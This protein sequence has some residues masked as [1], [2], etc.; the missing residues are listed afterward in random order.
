MNF[1]KRFF[2][3]VLDKIGLLGTLSFVCSYLITHVKALLDIKIDDLLWDN[4]I[5][6][7]I[8]QSAHAAFHKTFVYYICICI[9]NDIW[10][11]LTLFTHNLIYVTVYKSE[12]TNYPMD[13]PLK[14]FTKQKIFCTSI[15]LSYVNLLSFA[16]ALKDKLYLEVIVIYDFKLLFLTSLWANCQAMTHECSTTLIWC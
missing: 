13:L 7:C 12:Q 11:K 10:I 14:C 8:L 1:V 6:C 15:L 2:L 4:I 9:G 5:Q 3:D 16:V